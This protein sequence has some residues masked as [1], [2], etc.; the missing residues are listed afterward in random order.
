MVDRRRLR[1]RT[2]FPRT[3]PVSRPAEPEQRHGLAAWV[4]STKVWVGTVVVAVLAT[5]VTNGLLTVPGQLFNSEDA[6]DRLRQGPDF[7]VTVDFV[8]LDDEGRSGVTKD[9]FRPSA[10][11]ESLLARQGSAGTA[12]YTRLLHSIGAAGLDTLT[13]RVTL[14]GHRNQQID[15]KDLQPLIVTRTAPLTGTLL[16]APSQGDLSTMNMLIDMDR[17]F[18]VAHDVKFGGGPGAE[19][20]ASVEMGPPFF[21]RRTVTLR[22][23]EQQVLLIRAVTQRHY[24]AFRLEASYMLGSHEKKTVIDDHGKPFQVTALLSATGKASAYRSV[25]RL[26]QD[27]SM[28]RIDPHGGGLC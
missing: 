19:G 21:A 24:V 4:R 18:P 10:A 17:Q 28:R 15:I 14:T 5:L 13:L 16:C 22:D 3:R 12:A 26:Q 23:N 25:Y 7:S 11:Q 20:G 9:E 1:M 6:K 27:F 8:H 2:A